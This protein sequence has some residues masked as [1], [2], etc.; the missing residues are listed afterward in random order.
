[1]AG[2]N[3]L[4]RIIT[5]N[6]SG[7]VVPQ[8]KGKPCQAGIKDTK[9]RSGLTPMPGHQTKGLFSYPDIVVICGEPEYHDAY[10][11]IL[12][13]PKCI[14]EVLSESTEEFDRGEKFVLVDVREVHSRVRSSAF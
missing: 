6:L 8:L 14:I 2:E 4:H 5:A 9:V 7:I 10:G 1:M 12:L 3:P 13:N 11:D